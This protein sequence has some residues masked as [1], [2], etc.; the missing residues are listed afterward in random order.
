MPLAT[1]GHLGA[2]A[3][4]GLATVAR[5]EGLLLPPW[6]AVADGVVGAVAAGVGPHAIPRWLPRLPADAGPRGCGRGRSPA[7]SRQ[8]RST[9]S[10][11]SKAGADASGGEGGGRRGCV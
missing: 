5:G 7:G 10:H 11:A 6:A 3:P 1:G 2:H 8:R 9:S 4:P